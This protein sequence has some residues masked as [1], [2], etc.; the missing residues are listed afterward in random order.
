MLIAAT[1]QSLAG[2]D[3]FH[4]GKWY[5]VTAGTKVGIWKA[6]VDMAHYVTNVRG[7]AHQSFK[8]REQAERWYETKKSQGL[9]MLLAP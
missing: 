2:P 1:G 8:T 9:V 5:V 3:P 6:W 7:N 4:H